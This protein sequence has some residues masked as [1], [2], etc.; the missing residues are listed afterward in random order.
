MLNST[1]SG[2]GSGDLRGW[3]P[4]ALGVL[5]VALCCV[6]FCGQRVVAATV[7]LTPPNDLSAT[8]QTF[9]KTPGVMLRWTD[10][11]LDET[12]Y[13]VERRLWHPYI[14]RPWVQIY[15]GTVRSQREFFDPNVAPYVSYSYR[16]R[17]YR[18]SSTW[19]MNGAYSNIAT[20]RFSPPTPTPTPKPTPTPIPTP[21]PVPL[22]LTERISVSSE[23][24]QGNGNAGEFNFG[25]RGVSSDG[26]FVAFDSMASNLVAGD[27]NGIRDV[28]VRDT[29]AGTTERVSVSSSGAQGVGDFGSGGPT[30]SADGR[31]VAFYS[32]SP[33][34]VAND[35]NGVGVADI[36]VRDRQAGT[37]TLVSL[38]SSGTQANGRSTGAFLS[39]NGGF[40]A[41][42][43]NA[44]NLVAGDT[45]GIDDLFVRDLAA[46]VTTRVNVSSTGAQADTDGS[47]SLDPV[48]SAD[49]RYVA[50]PSW[51]SSLAENAINGIPNIFVRDRVA[52]TTTCVSHVDG[53]WHTYGHFYRPALSADGRFVA[54]SSYG[55]PN[56]AWVFDRQ[57]GTLRSFDGVEASLSADGRFLAAFSVSSTLVANDL[58]G[59]ADVFI[60][61]LQTGAVALVS[62]SSVGVQGNARSFAPAMSPDGRFVTYSSEASNMVADDSN[63][64]VDVFRTANPFA[65]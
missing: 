8:V 45:N 47:T 25:G 54:Y 3:L 52:A 43:S 38:N 2:S 61:D 6:V 62:R 34:L 58:N 49:G 31:Y 13:K 56:S 40:V 50:F 5:L 32:A 10:R 15:Q 28:F 37:T 41:F 48:I 27:T 21:T 33:N 19:V 23:E 26:R 55:G 53:T 36:F 63:G 9:F 18:A 57:T 44:S 24:V 12:G 1:K 29:V 64:V 22:T 51:D 65:P 42:Y 7:I 59:V 17:A 35:I 30:I 11:A 20:A 14:P 16:V 46:G 39:A 60:T 4:R